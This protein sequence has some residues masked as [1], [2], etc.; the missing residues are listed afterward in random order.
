MR[1]SKSKVG[2]AIKDEAKRIMQDTL[3]SLKKEVE[4][5]KKQKQIA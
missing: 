1:N 3:E 2:K 5:I 4:S